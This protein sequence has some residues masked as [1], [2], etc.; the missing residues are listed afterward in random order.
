MERGMRVF[1]LRRDIPLGELVTE[2]VMRVA[3][4]KRKG[5]ARY[6]FRLRGVS[7][8]KKRRMIFFWVVREEWVALGSKFFFFFRSCRLVTGKKNEA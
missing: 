4:G 8:R 1:Y 6:F 2:G 5:R 7:Q 3:W